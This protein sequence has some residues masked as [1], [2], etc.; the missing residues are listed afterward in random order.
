MYL[1]PKKIAL[2]CFSLGLILVASSLVLRINSQKTKKAQ[3]T[4]IPSISPQ[5]RRPH[6]AIN[7]TTLLLEIADT[8]EKKS[9]GLGN[10][11]PLADNE[12]MLFIYAPPQKVSFWMKDM[13]FSIDI[14]YI[15]QGKIVEIYANVPAPSPNTLPYQ[16]K[17]YP[18]HQPVDYVLETSAGWSEKNHIQVGDS[19][20]ISL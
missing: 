13:T 7:Q 16:L 3:E 6:I 5:P 14:I 11:K 20:K 4:P 10:H 17:S 12:G 1:S 8:P 19:V 2:I 9:R 18:A 15:N